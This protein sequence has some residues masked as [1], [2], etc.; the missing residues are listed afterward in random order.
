MISNIAGS[1]SC[2]WAASSYRFQVSHNHVSQKCQLA[3][4]VDSHSLLALSRQGRRRPPRGILGIL[5]EASRDSPEHTSC[6]SENGKGHG[7][8]SSTSVNLGQYGNGGTIDEL[9]GR[10]GESTY[11]LTTYTSMLQASCRGLMVT[12]NVVAKDWRGGGFDSESEPMSFLQPEANPRLSHRPTSK[13]RPAP[14]TGL[15]I[16]YHIFFCSRLSPFFLFIN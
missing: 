15:L 7:C 2:K 8:G 3:T 11:R 1:A 5:G 16:S 4:A 12:L 13:L 6:A 14:Q 10:R 9:G